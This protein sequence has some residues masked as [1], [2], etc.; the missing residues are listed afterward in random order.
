MPP[1]PHNSRSEDASP[2]I[3]APGPNQSC[4]HPNRL[5]I[6]PQNRASQV[7]LQKET[8]QSLSH[9]AVT[10]S[11]EGGM[12]VGTLRFLKPPVNSYPCRTY[13]PGTCRHR[14]SRSRI[15]PWGQRPWFSRRGPRRWNIEVSNGPDRR[16]DT[17]HRRFRRRGE[18][19][20]QILSRSRRRHIRRSA[21]AFSMK[22]RRAAFQ[23][24]ADRNSGSGRIELLCSYAAPGF[25]PDWLFG[26]CRAGSAGFRLSIKENGEAGRFHRFGPAKGNHGSG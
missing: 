21:Y 15:R 5:E 11:I 17:G 19:A 6:R 2:P 24:P 16:R 4:T 26:D 12:R 23:L 1:Y 18:R 13:R 25:L 8:F 9:L 14:T 20:S 10:L 22:C 3:A 7:R